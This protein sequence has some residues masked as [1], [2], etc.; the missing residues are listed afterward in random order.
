MSGNIGGNNP[1]A[2]ESLTMN[3][4]VSSSEVIE[5]QK[6]IVGYWNEMNRYTIN[7]SYQ[8][9]YDT[10][11]TCILDG[12]MP[13]ALRTQ[14]L[15]VVVSGTIYRNSETPKPRFGGEKTF[16]ISVRAIRKN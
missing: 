9:V 7:F 11:Y 4:D 6:A 5:N 13:E 2:T 8:G 16:W 14:G 1:N 12:E 15:Q 10:Q 3:N